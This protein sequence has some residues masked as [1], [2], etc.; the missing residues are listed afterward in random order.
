LGWTR[1]GLGSFYDKYVRPAIISVSPHYLEIVKKGTRKRTAERSRNANR[2]ARYRGAVMY[3]PLTADEA[4]Q[5]FAGLPRK[6]WPASRFGTRERL[7]AKFCDD[8]V[9]FYSVSSM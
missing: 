4:K 5:L 6:Y 8:F 7:A 2:L 3:R 9:R 1:S